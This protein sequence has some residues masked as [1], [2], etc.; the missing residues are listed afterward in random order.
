MASASTTSLLAF[1]PLLK[2]HRRAARLTQAQLAE[3]AGFSVVYVSMLERGARAPQRTTVALFA[4]ALALAPTERVALET[5]AQL[6]PANLPRDRRA[7]QAGAARSLP[8]GGFL[9]AV[10]TGALVGR[11]RELATI[12]LALDVVTN[13]QGRLLMLVGEPGV[14]KTRLAQEITLKAREQGFR[15]VTGRCYEPQQPVAYSPFLEALALAVAGADAAVQAQVSQQWP[16]VARLLPDRVASAPAAAVQ[17]DDRSAQQRL[18]WQVSGFLG[19]LA[20]Q[21]P[22]ALLLDDLQ[23]A[24]SAS[25]DLLAHLARHTRERR[26]LL[27][28]TARAVEAQRQPPLAAAL[29]DLRRDEL[30]EQIAV[31]RLAEEETSALIGATLRRAIPVEFGG[32]ESGDMTVAP[33]L[34]QLIYA[35]S[36]GNA[37]FTRQLARALQEQ[38]DLAF[39]EGQW[40][41]SADT[42]AP[43]MHAPESV[44][45]VI[46]QRLGRLS[47]LTQDVLREASVLGQVFA[48]DDL[49]GMSQRG[50]QEVE[51]ALAEAVGGGSYVRGSM[52][53]TA[54]ITRSPVTRS[55]PS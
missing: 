44:R 18:F 10:P 34:A 49:Q 41:L 15:V 54:S 36:E 19:A 27:V 24:D 38:G 52:I 39:A 50:E 3:R 16:E 22:L 2:R 21:E 26:L 20:E 1:G 8:I 14:G 5:A 23:W 31:R 47:A 35:R 28:G 7:E 32:G 37:F 17:L 42:A 33:P 48:F 46:G 25:L 45:A 9:G 6:P 11:A 13:G 55:T 40:R 29:S 53:A 12:A 51:E 30:L 4:D 43:A